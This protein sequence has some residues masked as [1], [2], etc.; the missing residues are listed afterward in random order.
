V[1]V[2]LGVPRSAAQHLQELRRSICKSSARSRPG[3]L[4]AAAGSTDAA[5]EGPAAFAALASLDAVDCALARPS[6]CLRLAFLP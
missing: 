4:A 2:Q 1:R 6:P 3:A 5:A